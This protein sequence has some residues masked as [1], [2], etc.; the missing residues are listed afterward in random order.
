MPHYAPK[1]LRRVLV[2]NGLEVFRVK[3]DEVHLAE[4]QNLHLM[5]AG[6]RIRCGEQ[7]SVTVVARA[8]RSDSPSRQAETQFSLVRSGIQRLLDAGF[9]ETNAESRTLH[10]VSDASQVVDVWYEI[11][12][13]G[14]FDDFDA[15][16]KH[17]KL[18]M[19]LDRYIAVE[20]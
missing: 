10:S 2:E 15:M 9:V 18:A 19:S 11:T 17:V 8:Q 16:L 3:D 12:V 7:Y 20:D 14:Q 5:E 4:R 1:E 6:V 13:V